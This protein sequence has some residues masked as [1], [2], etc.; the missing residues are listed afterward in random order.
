MLQKPSPQATLPGTLCLYGSN[1]HRKETLRPIEP[2]PFEFHWHL[3]RNVQHDVILRFLQVLGVSC[4]KQKIR[5]FGGLDNG[6]AMTTMAKSAAIYAAG[7]L[8]STTGKKTQRPTQWRSCERFL[9]TG[10]WLKL[11]HSIHVMHG[12]K[13]ND[14]ITTP[15]HSNS[16]TYNIILCTILCECMCMHCILIQY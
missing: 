11:L 6:G 7:W 1:Y 16:N 14:H 3:S 13:A 10:I 9:R 8:A 5:L 2:W 12:Y 4:I 15:I